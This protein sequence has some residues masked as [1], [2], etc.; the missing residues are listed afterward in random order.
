MRRQSA[1]LLLACLLTIVPGAA[2]VMQA[3]VKI[4]GMV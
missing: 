4:E 2:Q 1:W 3:T